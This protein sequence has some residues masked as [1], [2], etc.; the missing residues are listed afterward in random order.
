MVIQNLE[1]HPNSTFDTY[2]GLS[3]MLGCFSLARSE[4][5]HNAG[6][7]LSSA[8]DLAATYSSS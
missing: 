6:S 3:R 7:P 8:E 4:L 5:T 2:F 1:G